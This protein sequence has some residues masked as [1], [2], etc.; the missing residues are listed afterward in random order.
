MIIIPGY[1]IDVCQ[2]CGYNHDIRVF[3]Y[4]FSDLIFTANHHEAQMKIFF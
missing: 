2:S 1:N 4:D 3:Y